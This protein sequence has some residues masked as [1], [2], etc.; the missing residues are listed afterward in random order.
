[1]AFTASKLLGMTP[2]LDAAV[3]EL[4]RLAPEDQDRIARCLVALIELA[5]PELA[6]D[7]AWTR[8]F[9]ASPDALDRLAEEARAD[10]AAGRTTDLDPDR[11]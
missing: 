2:T 9:A 3:A 1:M 5:H 7:A 4:A 10:I 6:D 8:Q 11:L